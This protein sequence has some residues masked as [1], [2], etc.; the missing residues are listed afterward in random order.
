[1]LEEIAV[2]DTGDLIINVG[3]QHPSTH[4]V[5]HLIITLNGE[6]I[7]NIDPNLGYIHRSIRIKRL[8]CPAAVP[9]LQPSIETG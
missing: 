3:P 7:K 5:L 1:M 9:R 4:G 8:T 2:N 6:T